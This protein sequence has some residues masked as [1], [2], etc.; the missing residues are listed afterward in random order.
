MHVRY[1]LAALRGRPMCLCLCLQR[2]L[3]GLTLVL[4]ERVSH[5][6]HSGVT[7]CRSVSECPGEQSYVFS[8]TLED[9][10][11]RVSAGY[12]FRSAERVH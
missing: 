7:S 2:Y 6:V 4:A 8:A 1:V 11:R 10:F 12:H 3:R 9:A 5:E